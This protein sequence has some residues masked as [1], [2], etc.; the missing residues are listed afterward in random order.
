MAKNKHKIGFFFKWC[1]DRTVALLGLIILF[2]PLL[3]IAILIK[4]DSKGPVFFMQWRIGK[5]G[6]PFRICK[7]RTM[8]DERDENG[9]LL[10]DEIRLTPFGRKLRSTS[11]DEL[12]A[13]FNIWK[14]DMSVVGPR[15]EHGA[16]SVAGPR[17]HHGPVVGPWSIGS[18]AYKRHCSSTENYTKLIYTVTLPKLHQKGSRRF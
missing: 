15:G 10:P 6:K 14:G 13:L 8:T 2:L 18:S 12:L 7:F 9:E 17:G 5:D 11:L 1:F 3:I 4:I 16:V